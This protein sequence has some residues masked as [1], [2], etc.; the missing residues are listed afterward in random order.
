MSLLQGYPDGS[1]ITLL[2][3]QMF[4]GRPNENGKWSD[5]VMTIVFKDNITGEKHMEE[6]YD[7]DSD[8]YVL[9]PEYRQDYNQ[10]FAPIDQ[11]DHITCKNKNI[12]REIAKITGNMDFYQNNISNGNRRAN[13]ILHTDPSIFFSDPNIE[14]KYRFYFHQAYTDEVNPVTKCFFDI[15]ADTINMAGDFPE[16]G[17]CPVNA[18]TII[19]QNCKTIFTLLLRDPD[20]QQANDFEDEVK[21]GKTYEELKEF[22]CENVGGEKAFHNYN[23]DEYKFQMLFY[24]EE[25]NLIVDVFRIFNQFKPDFILA[26]NM[27]FDVPYL[28]ARISNLGYDPVGIMCHPD[29]TR[30][31]VYYFIDERVKNEPAERSDY[32]KISSYSVYLD[33][34]LLFA[35]RRKAKSYM[36]YSLD[37]IGGLIAKVHK[38]DY[39]SITTDLSKLPRL[40]YKVF[41]FYNI[42]DTIVQHCVECVNEDIEYTFSKCNMNCTRYSKCNRQTVYL[43]N[44]GAME[45]LDQGF[46]MGNNANRNTEPPK[47]KFPGAFVASP[48]K[49]NDY[50][51]YKLDGHPVYI[52]DNCDDFDYKALYPSILREFNIAP[53]TQIG[54]LI[55]ESQIHNKENRVH[56]SKWFRGGQFMEDIQCHVWLEFC[57]RWLHLAGYEDLYK[58]LIFYF[59]NIEIP[60]YNLQQYSFDGLYIPIEFY[61]KEAKMNDQERVEF[62]DSNNLKVP[63]VFYEDYPTEKIKEF[64]DHATLHPNQSFTRNED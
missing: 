43:T 5:D 1:D 45:F 64:V 58:D 21:S 44:R 26:W 48:K 15:E 25:I 10:L 55:I 20:N 30:Q 56:D 32:C 17:E 51:K 28:I 59:T 60:K 35:S 46:I 54:R 33:Q 2:N 40:N 18:V 52:F 49:L 16:P 29:F 61:G 39:K 13:S 19:M 8:F 11:L 36:S 4:R 9:K 14:D 57:E 31:E 41:V 7:P 53:N 24:D 50:S 42:F 37:F 63:I 6:I 12:T 47:S 38:L 22:I 3:S 27:A 23:L 62:D 34:M